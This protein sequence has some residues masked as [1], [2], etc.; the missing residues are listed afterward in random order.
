MCTLKLHQRSAYKNKRQ[1]RIYYSLVTLLYSPRR[2]TLN[3][4]L[5]KIEMV[6]HH[7]SIAFSLALP[8]SFGWNF[9]RLSAEFSWNKKGFASSFP[10]KFPGLCGEHLCRLRNSPL[11]LPLFFFLFSISRRQHP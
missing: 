2:R 11:F 7:A 10:P 6:F 9:V 4:N 1:T 5:L 8:A 3:H